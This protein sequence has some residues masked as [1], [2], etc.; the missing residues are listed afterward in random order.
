MD[1]DGGRSQ[2]SNTA[3]VVAGMSFLGVLQDESGRHTAQPRAGV[4][5]ET[6]E[7]WLTFKYLLCH[8]LMDTSNS[9]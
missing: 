9:I 4:V 8:A 1:R 3:G 6:Q 2:A 7:T 5:T